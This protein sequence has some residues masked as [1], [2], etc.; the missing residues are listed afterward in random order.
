MGVLAMGFRGILLRRFVLLGASGAILACAGSGCANS[1]REAY[2]RSSRIVLSPTAG[3]GSRITLDWARPA[4]GSAQATTF[5]RKP[6][7]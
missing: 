1:P 3:D 5:A 4:R 2:Y 6:V 7:H